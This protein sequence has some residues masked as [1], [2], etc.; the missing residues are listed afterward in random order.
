MNEIDLNHPVL[1]SLDDT[2]A[3][4]EWSKI[5]DILKPIYAVR[6]DDQVIRS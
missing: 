5:E 1:C 6:K 2:Q 3:L 4:L